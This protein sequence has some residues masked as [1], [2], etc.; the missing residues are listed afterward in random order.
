[1]LDTKGTPPW[2]ERQPTPPTTAGLPTKMAQT[3]TWN[4]SS[5]EGTT[6]TPKKKRPSTH[7]PPTPHHTDENIANESTGVH[8]SSRAR[9]PSTKLGRPET[10]SITSRAG[11]C[12]EQTHVN[13]TH[14]TA[15]QQAQR[16]PAPK[17]VTILPNKHMRLITQEAT[18]DSGARA[19]VQNCSHLGRRTK[20]APPV[21][22]NPPHLGRRMKL[23]PPV[24]TSPPKLR[25]WPHCQHGSTPGNDA[26]LTHHC[27]QPHCYCSPTAEED[28]CPN[29]Q[30]KATDGT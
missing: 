22:M 9:K 8:Q 17:Q 10:L 27:L 2:Y 7:Q 23:A 1:M 5:D 15:K 20:L 6:A 3:E 28:P 16:K 19:S 12:S 18:Q 26:V 14:K 24:V 21:V 4:L 25:A 29:S 11:K 13:S 30:Q